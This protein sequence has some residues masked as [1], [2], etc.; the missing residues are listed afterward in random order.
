MISSVFLAIDDPLADPD[1][2]YMKI[3]FIFNVIFT[4]L[5]VIEMILKVIAYGFVW[6]PDYKKVK[7]EGDT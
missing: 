2:T 4:V 7:S 1:S 3:I 6:R 5:F